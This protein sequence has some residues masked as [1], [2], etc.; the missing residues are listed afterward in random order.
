MTTPEK[1]L[2]LDE[3]EHV[4]IERLCD[5]YGDTEAHRAILALIARIR[6]LEAELA[7]WK[8]RYAQWEPKDEIISNQMVKISALK[9]GLAEALGRAVV[10][11]SDGY[12]FVTQAELDQWQRT[13]KQEMDDLRADLDGEPKREWL[14]ERITMLEAEL[15]E[16]RAGVSP[17]MPVAHST[18]DGPYELRAEVARLREALREIALSGVE[19]DDTRVDYVTIQLSRA[20]WDAAKKIAKVEEIE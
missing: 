19:L 1:L 7:E 4:S 18:I 8:A 10:H 17:L 3:I 11:A 9:D 20:T 5:Q 6:E 14:R 12:R 15:A 16:A 2:Y 13:T